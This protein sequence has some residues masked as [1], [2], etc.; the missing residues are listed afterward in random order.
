MTQYWY[1]LYT[2]RV[3]EDPKDDYRQLLGPYPTREEA[4]RA[5]EHAAR[6]TKR[7]EDEDAAY[8]GD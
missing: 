1:N 2:K 8:N 6:N 5:L 4:E 7:W 3:E